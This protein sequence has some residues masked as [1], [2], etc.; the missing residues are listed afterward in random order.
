MR[1]L[2]HIVQELRSETSEEV[3]RCESCG[4]ILYTLE[5]IPYAEPADG[6]ANAASTA[7]TS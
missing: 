3:Y 6:S 2:P 1:V 5:P 7:S 4:L